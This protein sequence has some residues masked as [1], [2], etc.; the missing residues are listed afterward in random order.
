[1]DIKD[2]EPLF[3]NWY[4][5]SFIGAGTFGK[6][7]KIK[8][9]EFGTDYYSA[10]KWIS[11]PQD[12][13][14][15]KQLRSDGMDNGSISM[16][17]KDVAKEINNEM[18]IMSRFIGRSS[19]VSYEDHRI[20]TKENEPGYDI[21]IRMEL[22]TSLSDYMHNREL[23]R[24]ELIRLGID[25]CDALEL[26][27]KY[28]IIHRDIKPDNIF[29]TDTGDF[30]LGDFGIAR[31]LERTAT[32]SKKGTYYYMA[33][34]VYKGERY[35]SSVDIYSLG[36]VLYRLL[37]AGRFPFLPLMP[38]PIRLSDRDQCLVRLM[39]GERKVPPQ[40]AE[41]QLGDIVLKACAYDPKDRYSSPRQM[42]EELQAIQI[43]KD[44]AKFVYRDGDNLGNIEPSKRESEPVR[45]AIDTEATDSAFGHIPDLYSTT[46]PDAEEV[47]EEIE[48][49]SNDHT[50]SASGQ[51]IERNKESAVEIN[52]E[53]NG[54]DMPG[55]NIVKKRRINTLMK[56]GVIFIALSIIL[57]VIWYYGML[58]GIFPI[59]TMVTC[60]IGAIILYIADRIGR[61]LPKLFGWLILFVLTAFL[62][63][64]VFVLLSL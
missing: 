62:A 37:N 52:D 47:G 28:N 9:E 2:F 42:R 3:G 18:H 20:L 15:L 29:V 17:Y 16:Y 4:V 54:V 22:L 34:E 8:R 21:F 38:E 64:T 30:K 45:E 48:L 13:A 53:K 57:T 35:N 61:V 49:E 7:Y 12:E 25:I 23:S 51:K 27:Q 6:V 40:N 39:S 59:L 1:M 5:E 33:P 14:E 26:C 50:H 56:V 32:G 63:F 43:S 41:G 11:I 58:G 24:I 60:Y 46:I 44:D 36:I 31:Q 55:D 19:I 10:L